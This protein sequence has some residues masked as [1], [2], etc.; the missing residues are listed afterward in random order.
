MENKNDILAAEIREFMRESKEEKSARVRMD[1]ADCE[2]LSKRIAQ[3]ILNHFVTNSFFS[4]IS[5]SPALKPRIGGRSP[6]CRCYASF[7]TDRMKEASRLLIADTSR[8][9]DLTVVDT[10]KQSERNMIL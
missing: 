5:S 4:H 6:A 10:K 2:V 1:D 7:S 9:A 8:D 3:N